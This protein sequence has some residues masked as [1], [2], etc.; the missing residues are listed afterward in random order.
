MPST[1]IIETPKVIQRAWNDGLYNLRVKRNG[2]PRGHSIEEKVLYVLGLGYKY[3]GS[4]EVRD[5]EIRG[6]LNISLDGLSQDAKFIKIGQ[7]LWEQCSPDFIAKMISSLSNINREQSIMYQSLARDE[8]RN[9]K[10]YFNR[11]NT[12]AIK[13]YGLD[14]AAV[15]DQ[16]RTQMSS[17]RNLTERNRERLQAQRN[18]IFQSQLSSK[19]IEKRMV[20]FKASTA[21]TKKLVNELEI[22]LKTHDEYKDVIPQIAIN[23]G[24]QVESG[25]NKNYLIEEIKAVVVGYVESE[26]LNDSAQRG[27]TRN[28][29]MRVDTPKGITQIKNLLKYTTY[30]ILAS[31][32]YV[33]VDELKQRNEQVAT[34]RALAKD[35]SDKKGNINYKKLNKSLNRRDKLLTRIFKEE[36]KVKGRRIKTDEIIAFHKFLTTTE[37]SGEK[38]KEG[39]ERTVLLPNTRNIDGTEVG[40]SFLDPWTG[41]QTNE[42]FAFAS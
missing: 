11:R 40:F 15:L 26:L 17:N 33:T 31:N 21:G 18:R 36:D 41:N 16:E 39:E 8:A 2:N 9:Y 13:R 3:K 19:G 28:V 7:V 37:V 30:S 20:R 32:E 23:L 25:Y 38:P 14:P 42:H 27:S 6:S 24:I 5:E 12:R 35:F 1:M 4:V 22:L 29:Y 10:G 34:M